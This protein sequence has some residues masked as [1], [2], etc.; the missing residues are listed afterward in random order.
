M[1][2]G[3]Y[4]DSVSLCTSDANNPSV[5]SH[6]CPSHPCPVAVFHE[7]FQVGSSGPPDIV[8]PPPP[9]L[10]FGLRLIQTFYPGCTKRSYTSHSLVVLQSTRTPKPDLVTPLPGDLDSVPFR[11]L[12]SLDW[13]PNPVQYNLH[14]SVTSSW[15]S[16]YIL[17]PGVHLQSQSLCL[18][19]G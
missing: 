16:T 17:T 11:P 18:N 1:S 6:L 4:Q 15:P 3:T 10:L 2:S 5:M 12:P 9:W 7:H 13:K 19:S 8:G 14:D